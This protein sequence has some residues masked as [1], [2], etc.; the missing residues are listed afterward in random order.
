[1]YINIFNETSLSF[2]LELPRCT[3]LDTNRL[4]MIIQVVSTQQAVFLMLFCFLARR[5]IMAR[6][7]GH[8][9]QLGLNI[10]WMLIYPHSHVEHFMARLN[11][12]FGAFMRP[13][14][15]MRAEI[16]RLMWEFIEAV[17]II[18]PC[19]CLCFAGKYNRCGVCMRGRCCLVWEFAC[20][21]EI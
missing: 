18:I 14:W 6:L 19:D 15:F 4:F 20:P 13:R 11:E 21:E 3:L 1:M 17:N 8:I 7:P 10:F 16:M 9:L 2:L 5:G 12:M